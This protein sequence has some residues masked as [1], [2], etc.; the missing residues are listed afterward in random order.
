MS[1]QLKMVISRRKIYKKDITV[2]AENDVFN[3]ELAKMENI[4]TKP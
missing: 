1:N 4:I 3:D 2:F